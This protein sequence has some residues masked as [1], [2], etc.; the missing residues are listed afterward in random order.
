[1]EKKEQ[2]ALDQYALTPDLIEALYTQEKITRDMREDALSL[3]H[4]PRQ[5]AL[6][7]ARVLLVVG[8]L[9]LL[10]GV[11]FFFAFNWKQIP[12]LYKFALIELGLISCL[13]GAFLY[14]LQRLEGQLLLFSASLFVGFFWIIFGQ[15]YP[16]DADSHQLFGI[17]AFLIFGW[18]F[19]SNF[20]PHWIF[21]LGL[22]NLFFLLWSLSGPLLTQETKTFP[23]LALILLNGGSLFLRE[24]LSKRTKYAWMQDPWVRLV[25]A[26]VTL[27]AMDIP[28][29]QLIAQEHLLKSVP[30]SL[31][32]G[33]LIG[34][35][36]HGL[37][38][39]VYRY[40]LPDMRAL[41]AIALSGVILLEIL[42]IRIAEDFFRW[43]DPEPYLFILL[44]TLGIVM[45]VLR[46]L[47][48]AAQE[49]GRADV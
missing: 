8:L 17:W 29:V 20:A 34:I 19:V 47:H 25:L 27:I 10:S 13:V 45:I 5:W 33:G 31:A 24:T 36:G 28:I 38:Y 3:F 16:S 18:V 49:I 2:V 15:I 44:S 37:L 1:M 23:L 48:A 42:A 12:S 41:T 22:M 7:S 43:K 6:W 9:L 30:L 4:S 39:V 40:R 46:L 14:T 26:G 32:I 21:W 35:G 11:I